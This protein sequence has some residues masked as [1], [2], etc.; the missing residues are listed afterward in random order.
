MVPKEAFTDILEKLVRGS[1]TD[2]PTLVSDRFSQGFYKMI[3][4]KGCIS[5]EGDEVIMSLF[6]KKLAKGKIDMEYLN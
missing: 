1:L 6:E 2:T 3:Q 4:A 5:P